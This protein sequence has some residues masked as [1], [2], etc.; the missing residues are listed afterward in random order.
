MKLA[1]GLHYTQFTDEELSFAKQT[2]ADFLVVHLTDYKGINLSF[3]DANHTESFSYT[4]ANFGNWS[5]PFLNELQ[6][7]ASKHGLSV[8]A[9]ENFDPGHWYDVLLDG[10]AREQQLENIRQCISNASAAGITTIHYNFSLAGIWGWRKENVARGGASSVVFDMNEIDADKPI[11]NGMVWNMYYNLDAPKGFVQ[12]VSESQIWERLSYFLK[13]ILSHAEECGVVLAAHPD[14]PPLETLRQTARLINSPEK[15]DR[16]LGINPSPAN[17]INFCLGTTQEMPNSN[18]YDLLERLLE[19]DAV[20]IV[21]F[22]NV[23]GKIPR[24][25]EVFPDEGDIDMSRII[26]IL[27]KYNYKGIL[28]PDHTPEMTCPAPWHAG[29]AYTMGYIIGL[30]K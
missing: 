20:K 1:L 17:G 16:L 27:K 23:K 26:G 14:D 7:K 25:F 21:H 18:I 2:G 15:Y 19:I 8:A 24:Y 5:V 11:P 22:R 13:N 10:P 3:A 29:M 28:M 30:I 6:A 12:P 9:I 4:N